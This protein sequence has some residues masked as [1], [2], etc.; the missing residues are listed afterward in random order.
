[1]GEGPLPVCD[2]DHI[3]RILIR[4][5]FEHKG[6]KGGERVYRR[7]GLRVTVPFHG[8]GKGVA[9]GTLNRIIK[10]AQKPRSEFR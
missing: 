3:A 4:N 10:A 7:N 1:M 9:P 8:R 6:G 5:G 2:A